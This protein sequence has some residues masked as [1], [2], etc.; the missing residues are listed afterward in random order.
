MR[1]YG[2]WPILNRKHTE[3][4]AHITPIFSYKNYVRVIFLQEYN[5]QQKFEKITFLFYHA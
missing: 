2:L 4:A 5:K 3:A 1:P